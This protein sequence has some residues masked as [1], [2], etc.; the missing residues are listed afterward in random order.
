M[1]ITFSSFSSFE[2][3]VPFLLGPLWLILE[4]LLNNFNNFWRWM[5]KGKVKHDA[6]FLIKP[7]SHGQCN[8]HTPYLLAH[9]HM[10]GN[11]FV[12]GRRSCSC[13]YSKVPSQSLPSYKVTWE[14]LTIF[15]MGYFLYRP[16]IL[17]MCNK[18]CLHFNKNVPVIMKVSTAFHGCISLTANIC[19][20]RIIFLSNMFTLWY[21]CDFPV[22]E[23]P[24][25]HHLYIIF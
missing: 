6:E 14:I 17:N 10:P 24:K 20:F 5:F 23:Y 21:W 4:C 15:R 13:M 18:A 22:S 12:S 9:Q 3:F 16:Q 11:W 25:L 7:L 2:A 19:T 8:S 1:W